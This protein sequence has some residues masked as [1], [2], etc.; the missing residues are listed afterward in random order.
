MS[1]LVDT[2]AWVEFLRATGGPHHLW[3]R[4]AI[5]REV[6][7]GWTDP[8]LFELMAGA[9]S[10]ESAN[11]LRSLLLRGPVLALAGLADWEDAALLYRLARA[12]GLTLRSANDCLIATVALRT[13]TRLLSRDR[14]FEALA[15]VS[16][17]MLVDPTE[18]PA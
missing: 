1:V 5:Q 17:L 13:R 16:D 11:Q 2:S 6:P 10:A 14:D 4:D 9:R 12:R 18:T 3:L 7:L 15:A 8:I